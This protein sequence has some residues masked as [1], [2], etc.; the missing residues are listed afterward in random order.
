MTLFRSRRRLLPCLHRRCRFVTDGHS[1]RVV[2][3][4]ISA[5]RHADWRLTVRSMVTTER[6]DLLAA[7]GK[8]ASPY[9]LPVRDGLLVAGWSPCSLSG[10]AVGAWALSGSR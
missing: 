3:H 10:T 7:G 5:V 6:S 2:R 4:A 1:S 9:S 8:Q